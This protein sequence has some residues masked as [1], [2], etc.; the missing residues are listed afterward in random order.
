M[1]ATIQ[2][3]SALLIAVA[4]CSF[5]LRAS[6]IPDVRPDALPDAATDAAIDAPP[7]A[8]CPPDPMLRGCFSFDQMPLPAVLANE[9]TAT[10]AATLTGITRVARTATNGAA[11]LGATSSIT[12]PQGS[13]ID[14]I[15]A[16]EIWFRADSFPA[17]NGAR[18]GLVDSN[19]I[20]P[21]ISLFVYR[22]DPGH[23]LRCGIGGG[24]EAWT[25]TLAAG[26]WYYA[27]CT[28]ESG[29][30]AVYLNGTLVG[31]PRAGS[32]A[33]AGALVSQGFTIGSDNSGN[34]N[35]IGERI[36]GAIDGVRLWSVARTA[37]EIALTAATGQ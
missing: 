7:A 2:H 12:L 36:D 21:N 6:A 27:A 32:C 28:C 34:P 5:E 26:T 30:L 11:Q 3:S 8:F 33:S 22:A 1:V 15:L 16:I 29:N 18:V 9:G 23:T 14:G 4:G 31:S 17:F 19:V 24:L 20:P 35:V 13:G 10:I 37:N 25:T